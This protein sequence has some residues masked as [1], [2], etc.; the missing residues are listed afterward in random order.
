MVLGSAKTKKDIL[1]KID[2]DPI[3]LY[4]AP[5]KV[6]NKIKYLGQILT[7]GASDSVQ[8][9]ILHQKGQVM[10][11]INQIVG[12]VYDTRA[13]AIGGINVAIDVWEMALLPYLLNGA[14]TWVKMRKSSMEELNKIHNTFL[15]RILKVILAVIPLMY[16]DLGQLLMVNWVMKLKLL[17][18][19]H[20]ATLDA[21]SIS[22]KVYQKEKLYGFDGLVSEVK[23]TLEAS[24]MSLKKTPSMN[25]RQWYKSGKQEE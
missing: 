14:G 10:L 11:A 1:K 13:R 9:T 20:I 25:G 18:L 16:W 17:L 5:I 8:S 3:L 4:G 15:Q 6:E 23:S 22:F 7:S 2:K 24:N 12:M 21:N 19:H